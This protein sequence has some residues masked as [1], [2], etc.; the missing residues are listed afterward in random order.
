MAPPR[1][2]SWQLQAGCVLEE[3][4]GACGDLSQ[5]LLITGAAGGL[6][7]NPGHRQNNG[8]CKQPLSSEPGQRAFRGGSPHWGGAG[9]S[10]SSSQGASPRPSP[11]PDQFLAR[12]AEIGNPGDFRPQQNS[13]RSFSSGLF[14]PLGW[15]RGGVGLSGTGCTI[16]T[17][18]RSRRAITGPPD[19]GWN[20]SQGL[21]DWGAPSFCSDPSGDCA[22]TTSSGSFPDRYD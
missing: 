11:L 22:F 3:G 16:A 2:G 19:P 1:Q 6:N 17:S 5:P 13:Q 8:P 15:G 18:G 9:A 21:P 12:S 20:L 7:L 4:W 10:G 14:R